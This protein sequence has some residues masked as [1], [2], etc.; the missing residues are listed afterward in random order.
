M[1]KIAIACQ[2]G[3][4]QTAFTAGVL[5]SL[6]ASEV[7]RKTQVVSLSGTSGGAICASLTWYGLLKKAAGDLTPIPERIFDFWHELTA[8]LPAEQ[9]FD[10]AIAAWLRII[11]R[12]IIP[13]F[14]MSP[15]SVAARTMMGFL[16][17]MLPRRE[18]TDLKAML[19]KH[20]DFGELKDLVKADS[21]VL[22]VG[23]ADVLTGELKKFNSRKGEICVEAI[24]AS[25]AVPTLFPAVELAGH[26]YWDGLFSDNPPVQELIRARS[27]GGERVPDEVWVIQ[28]NP[29]ECKTVPT[30]PGEIIDRRN[31]MVGNISLMQ[32]LELIELVNLF[33]REGALSAEVLLKFGITKRDPIEIRSIQMSD[34]LLGSLDYVSKLTRGPGHIET[35]MA[36]GEKQ[37]QKFVEEYLAQTRGGSGKPAARAEAAAEVVA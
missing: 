32:N 5:R 30:T 14:E 8:R 18:F 37:G 28:I 26:Y 21:P 15:A 12:G 35:L 6:F 2:G 13:R 27:V 9:A 31:Q 20:I 17:S 16:S 29:T 11:D 22:L 34:D 10:D 25:A 33:L 23:A 7:D 3:G 24:L 1:R 4:S 19:E 36:D